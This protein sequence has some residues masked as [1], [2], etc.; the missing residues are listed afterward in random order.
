MILLL[1]ATV[2]FGFAKTYFMARMINA[3]LPNR[4]IHI[5]AVAFTLWMVLLVVQEGL[6]AGRKIK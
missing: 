5:H 4:L 3:P 2:L 1:W 6:V